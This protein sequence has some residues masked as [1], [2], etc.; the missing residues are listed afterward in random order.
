MKLK[1]K[2]GNEIL[3]LFNLPAI[4]LRSFCSLVRIFTKLFSKT[5]QFTYK[6]YCP[7]R[8]TFSVVDDFN[9]ILL[10]VFRQVFQYFF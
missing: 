1:K 6:N 2:S 9:S 3:F 4:Q 5:T 10:V 8:N 7:S